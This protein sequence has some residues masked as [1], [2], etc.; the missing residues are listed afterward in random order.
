MKLL[1][2]D[3]DQH[4]CGYGAPNLRLHGVL[5][6][7]E[8]SLDAQVLLDPSEEQLDLPAALVERGDRQRWQRRVVGQEDQRL[9]RLRVLEANTRQMIRVVLG[10]VEAI[11]HDA[12]IA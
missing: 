11:E 10:R 9:A 7:A 1:L 5:A 4:V 8:E 6:G 3:G 12:L 2:D